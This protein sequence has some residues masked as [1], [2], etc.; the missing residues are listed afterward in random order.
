LIIEL[1]HMYVVVALKLFLCSRFPL[2]SIFHPLRV[3]SY[4]I[5]MDGVDVQ[6]QDA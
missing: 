4:I 2:L 5:C 3:S 6:V 1:Y